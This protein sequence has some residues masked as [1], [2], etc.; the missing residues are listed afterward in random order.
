M[1][2]SVRPG[3]FLQ[4]DDGNALRPLR[5]QVE[6]LAAIHVDGNLRSACQRLGLSYRSGWDMLGELGKQLGG[7]VVQ[8]TR[9]RGSRLSP[10]GEKLLAAQN[11][12]EARIGPILQSL[13]IE[14]DAD[15]QGAITKARNNLRVFASH[16]FAIALLGQK[17]QKQGASVDLT[18]RGSVEALAGLMRGSCDVA[19]FHVPVGELEP[20]A[21]AQLQSILQPDFVIVGFASRRQGLMVAPGNPLGLWSIE[22]LFKPDVHFVNRQPGSGTRLILDLLLKK[23]GHDG[24]RIS[25]FE[26]VEL[27]HAAVAAFIASGKANAGLGVEAAARQFN[28][29]FVPLVNERYFLAF[30]RNLQDDP[31]LQPVFELLAEPT[32]KS[33]VN[34]LPGYDSAQMG[35]LMSIAQAFPVLGR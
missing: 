25:G 20:Y 33:E 23:A 21:L 28:L 10:L 13:S 2:L 26:S 35:Q 18:F 1:K 16:G 12:V 19:G 27:T 17:L 3:L 4:D 9:G 24:M 29:D 7:E 31:R 34:Q 30:S 32:F 15:I 14:V 22:D 11:L 8:M 6:L 5:R